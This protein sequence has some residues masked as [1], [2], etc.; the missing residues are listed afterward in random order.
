MFEVSIIEKICGKLS[1][2]RYKFEKEGDMKLFIEM[3]K[4]DKGI[5]M[6]HTKEVA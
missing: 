3:C 2:N 5:I 4:S 1:V 6:I